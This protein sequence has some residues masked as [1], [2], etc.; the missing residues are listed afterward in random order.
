MVFTPNEGK[1][2]KNNGFDFWIRTYITRQ[3]KMQIV[4]L[5]IGWREH[6]LSVKYN[7]NFSNIRNVI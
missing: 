6:L 4:P 2:N 3:T 7:C 1:G 5:I